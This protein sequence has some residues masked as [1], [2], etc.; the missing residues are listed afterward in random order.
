MVAPLIAAEARA[1]AGRAAARRGAAGAEELARRRAQLQ[2]QS[3]VSKGETKRH[4]SKPV[5]G[6]M[7]TAAVIIDCAQFAINLVPVL[8]QF[9]GLML[10]FIGFVSFLVWFALLGVNFFT[11]RKAGLKMMAGFGATIVELV[12]LVQALPALTMG[13]A[14]TII[15]S[16]L[17]D[18]E[19]KEAALKKSR[20]LA[21]LAKAKDDEYRARIERFRNGQASS[22]EALPT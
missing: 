21:R 12:P 14:V 7:V 4:I 10:S 15:A 2:G 19:D 8:G 9:F 13:V 3:Q 11:G 5:A 1:L 20:D 16:W 6:I 18:A 17:E 22:G